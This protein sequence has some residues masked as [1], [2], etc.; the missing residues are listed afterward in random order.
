VN[1]SFTGTIMQSTGYAYSGDA[2]ITASITAN[3]L[4]VTNVAS[5]VLATGSVLTDTTF[6]LSPATTI[7]E[8]LTGPAG[9]IGTYTVNNPQTVVSETMNAVGTGQRVPTYSTATGVPMQFQGIPNEQLEMVGALNIA[10]V[11]RSVWL[12]GNHEALDRPGVKGGDLLLVPTGLVN[13]KPALDVW[14]TTSQP[15]AWDSDNWCNVIVTLQLNT[16]S[17]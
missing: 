11:M 13:P 15:A 9:G 6:T 10:G 5:G 8:Q 4:T 12:Y 14:L 7:L 3:V 2:V 16:Q 1:Q 17:Q